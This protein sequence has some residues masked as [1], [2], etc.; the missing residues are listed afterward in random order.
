[1]PGDGQRPRIGAIEP[2]GALGQFA[3]PRHRR[4]ARQRRVGRSGPA[5]AD[6]KDVPIGQPGMRR[7]IGRVEQYGAFQ[8]LPGGDKGGF[9]K[10]VKCGDR[11]QHEVIGGGR[12]GGPQPGA[13]AFVLH[14]L[15]VDLRHRLGRD[16]VLQRQQVIGIA[17][18]A[19]G[20]DHLAHW[21][22]A[23]RSAIARGGAERQMCP[24]AQVQHAQ[25]DANPGRPPLDCRPLDRAL[26]QKVEV[27]SPPAGAG[28]GRNGAGDRRHAGAGD[29][30]QPAEARQRRGDL[31][32]Q[33]Q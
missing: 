22:P 19:A 23:H 17:V 7:G 4:I 6:Q 5:L 21:N 32:G 14:Q 33:A 25:A 18:E 28:I 24:T 30:E 31:V 11:P 10:L 20:P 26:Q 13:A 3:G 9:L 1:M 29:Q 15:R 27:E 12:A 8:G 16:F 2:H